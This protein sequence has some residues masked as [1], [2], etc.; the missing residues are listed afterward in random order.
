MNSILGTLRS[1]FLPPL[2]RQALRSY[3]RGTKQEIFSFLND[4]VRQHKEMHDQLVSRMSVLEK[5]VSRLEQTK[6]DGPPSNHGCSDDPVRAE[7]GQTQEVAET[8]EAEGGAVAPSGGATELYGVHRPHPPQPV[9]LNGDELKAPDLDLLQFPGSDASLHVKLMGPHWRR[10]KSGSITCIRPGGLIFDFNPHRKSDSDS[11]SQG[12]IRITLKPEECTQVLLSDP[13]VELCF[14]RDLKAGT[15]AQ[16]FV[17]KS[18]RWSPVGGNGGMHLSAVLSKQHLGTTE[19]FSVQL[20][21]P[22]VRLLQNIMESSVPAMTGFV[23]ATH[24]LS[25]PWMGRHVFYGQVGQCCDPKDALSVSLMACVWRE[26]QPATAGALVLNIATR[27]CALKPVDWSRAVIV[28]LR[29]PDCARF[30]SLGPTG[31]FSVAPH[32]TTFGGVAEATVKAAED[33]SGVLITASGS[34]LSHQ[35]FLTWPQAKVIQ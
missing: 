17:T 32:R 21:R 28:M 35:I 24:H 27:E 14:E 2:W 3:A 26:G 6:G 25:P 23:W 9:A 12:R 1:P 7:M 29:P 30:A 16:G 4:F 13:E 19:N 18:M 20:L 11:S 34:N 22:Q 10:T 8:M 5:T 31:G 33:G 15:P